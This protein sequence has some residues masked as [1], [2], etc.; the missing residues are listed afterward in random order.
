LRVAFDAPAVEGEVRGFGFAIGS[1]Q[2]SDLAAAIAA[3][4]S[5]AGASA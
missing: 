4:V 5:G 1:V 3:L 2:N